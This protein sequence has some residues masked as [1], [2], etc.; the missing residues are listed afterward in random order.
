DE[1]SKSNSK[2]GIDKIVLKN[3]RKKLDDKY[4]PDK[5]VI[6]DLNS[7]LAIQVDSLVLMDETTINQISGKYML[8]LD[9]IE[10]LLKYLVT[11][12]TLNGKRIEVFKKF[13]QLVKNAYMIYAPDQDVGDLASEFMNKYRDPDTTILLH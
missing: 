7:N 5:R 2:L 10:S 1:F 12:D 13:V 11:A 6:N 3:Y 9:E 4:K 8:F